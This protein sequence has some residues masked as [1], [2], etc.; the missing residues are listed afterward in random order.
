MSRKTISSHLMALSWLL[1]IPLLGMVYVFLNRH[2][3]KA[4]SLVTDFDRHI[5]FLKIFILPYVSWLLFILVSL[6]YLCMRNRQI[7]YQTLIYFNVG[8]L[9]CYGI[10]FFFQTSVPRPVLTGND[11]LT[12]MV[13]SIYHLDEPYNCFPSTHV[14]TSYFILRAFNSASNIS[15]R[16]RVGVSLMSLLIMV[17]ILFVKQHVLLDLIGAVGVVEVIYF[18]HRRVASKVKAVSLERQHLVSKSSGKMGKESI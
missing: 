4:Y 2:N 10:Y 18:I 1:S 6:I 13:R 7:Y 15:R 3:V 11:G 12:N 17:S 9:V 14:L 5:P 8:L 16:I